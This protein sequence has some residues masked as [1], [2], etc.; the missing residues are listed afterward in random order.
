MNRIAPKA[1]EIL[2]NIWLISFD[3]Q[4][5][6]ALTFLRFQEYYESPRFKG[7][8]FSL[9]DFKEW[10][11]SQHGGEFSYVD[12]WSGFNVPSWVMKPFIDGAFDPLSD[13]EKAL[14]GMLKDKRDPFYLIGTNDSL[15]AL[16]HEICHALFY[17]DAAYRDSVTA[18]IEHNREKLREV[19]DKMT[20]LGYHESVA[21]DEVH[22]YLCA[23]PDWLISSGISFDIQISKQLQELRSEAARRNKL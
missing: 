14:I 18:T 10:Y 17:V 22:A 23:N 1:V 5:D 12:D 13:L 9:D 16:E 11:S 6:L 19:F 20:E 4:E 21:V 15:D 8:V 2:K 7:Q 3:T